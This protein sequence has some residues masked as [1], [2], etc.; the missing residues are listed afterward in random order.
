MKILISGATGFLGKYVL[1]ELSL[2]GHEVILLVRSRASMIEV[3]Q[4]YPEFSFYELDYLNGLETF[5]P[6]SSF[7]VFL[8]LAWGNLD[9][10]QSSHHLNLELP[11]QKNLLGWAISAGI[12][13]IVSVGTCL[14]YSNLQGE[15]NEN[16]PCGSEI[17]YAMAKN[18]LREFLRE[19]CSLS[20]FD[21]TWVRLF[22]F[23]GPGQQDRTLFG[24]LVN[25]VRQKHKVF[26][27]L[28]QGFQELDYMHVEDVAKSLVRILLTRQSHGEVN[29]CSGQ[30]RTLREIANQWIRDFEWDVQISWGSQESREYESF[31]FWGSTRKLAAIKAI[32]DLDTTNDR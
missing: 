17:P 16:S 5:T 21:L 20:R 25:A 26:N 22:Y 29:I 23:Y 15:L 13:S 9:D 6:D 7:D 2:T 10:F 27:A 12:K 19:Q 1:K 32:C 24:Q 30:P 28:S 3:N 31:P 14:E 11:A 8:N 18:Q 4:D